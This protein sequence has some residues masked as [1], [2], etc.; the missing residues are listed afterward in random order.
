V[1]LNVVIGPAADRGRL[2]ACSG[3]QL[4]AAGPAVPLGCVRSR[5]R[6]L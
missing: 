2:T 1:A 4:P 6:I 5:P 3:P